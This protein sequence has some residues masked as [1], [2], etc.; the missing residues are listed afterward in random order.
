MNMP[1][2]HTLL[3]D[4]KD[5]VLRIKLNRPEKRN[6]F[7]E[8]MVDELNS[9]F[10]TFWDNNDIIGVSLTGLG[11]SFCSG[12]DLSYLQSLQKKSFDENLKD[13]Q[14]LREMY[15]NIYSFPKPTLAL[16]NGP[17]VAGGCGLITVLDI[18]IA[19]KNAIF[20]YPEVKIGFVASIVSVFLIQAIGLTMAKHL[21]YTGDLIDAQEAEK[22]GL[23]HKVVDET[24]LE[25]AAETFFSKIGE[26]SP[27]AIR[28]TKSL[29]I[30]L[31]AKMIRKKLDIACELNAESRQTDDFNE[32]LQS[33]L[34]KRKPIWRKT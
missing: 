33:F 17:A 11:K 15:W 13:S 23:V 3:W 34:E 26:N 7:N 21:L 16:V 30:N 18:A 8:K 9:I 10:M 32:G 22:I 12:A 5:D 20:G 25:K 14:K 27:Q 28:Q 31:Q 2:Y 1:K 29:L 4:V 24:G 6:S 19:S